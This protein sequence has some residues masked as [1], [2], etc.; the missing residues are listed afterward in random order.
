MYAFENREKPSF[1]RGDEVLFRG[2]GAWV[3]TDEGEVIDLPVVAAEAQ[4][5]TFA[6]PERGISLSLS[7]REYGDVYAW[8]VKLNYRPTTLVGHKRGLHLDID[9]PCGIDIAEIPG[10]RAY[11][12]NDLRCEFWCRAYIHTDISKIPVKTQALLWSDKDAY[13]FASPVCDSK[14][15]SGFR[16]NILGGCTLNITANTRLSH[17]EN[18]VLYGS[19]GKDP[20]AL[21]AHVIETAL[22]GMGK[23]G[24]LRE[25]RRY[26]EMLEYLGWCSWDAFHMDVTHQNLIDKAEEF[27]A[28]NIPVRWFILDDMWGDAPHDSRDRMGNSELNSFEAAPERFP[29]GLRGIISELHDRYQLLVGIWHPTNGYWGGID[30]EGDL[31]REMKDD[32]TVCSNGKLVHKMEPDA[33]F[34][35]YE[36]QH[37]FYR[38]CGASFVKV[39]NQGFIRRHYRNMLPIGEAGAILHRAIEAS[40][41]LHFDGNMI[42]C[43]C[44]ASENFW[45]RPTSSVCRFS[46]DFQPEDRRWFVQHLIQ[47]SFNSMIQGSVYYGDWDMWWSDDAQAPKN[48]VLRA[49]SGGPVYMSDELGRSIRETIMPIVWSDGRIL[50]LGQPARPTEDCLLTD[51][52]RSGRIF[53]VFNRIGDCG[54]I[55]AFNLDHDEREVE[56]HVSARD[57][58]MQC[59][60]VCLYDYFAGTARAIGRA[61]ELPLIL[62]NYDDFRLF[63]LIPIVN[64]TAVIGLIDKYMTPATYTAVDAHTVT[65]RE[66]GEFALYS[67]KPI[68]HITVNGTQVPL[69]QK[70][71]NLYTAVLEGRELV[72]TF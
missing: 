26:P 64:G 36:R 30:P 45:N 18:D 62:K 35:Y 43:M 21:C 22:R 56:G 55:A 37:A 33:A 14:C 19:S 4:S 12:A 67:E 24:G 54:V 34:R 23:H 44:M 50:R 11:F 66:G 40:V 49:M 20:Y 6:L 15:K 60:R 69:L 53:K 3:R 46:G 42:N 7:L 25:S 10:L 57:A 1:C 16:G 72:V 48:A 47:C 41:G 31:A 5:L 27:R 70:A 8:R 68:S 61:E 51:P 38:D 17:A 28:K 32:L 13:S 65:L 29:T 58:R 63:L 9:D 52:E 71:E 39:D 2:I 59:D